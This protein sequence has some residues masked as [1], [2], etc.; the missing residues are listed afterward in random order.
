MFEELPRPTIFAHRG[1]SAHAPE[2][3]LAAFELA[4]RQ[5]ADAI[6][7]D[8]MLCGDDQM[9]VFHDE[10]LE[11]TTDGSGLVRELPL[12]ALKELDAGGFFDARFCGEK[13]PTLEE[14]FET[15]GS[16]LFINI[17]IKNYASPRDDLPD[18]VAELVSKYNLEKRVIVSS[19]NPFA[20]KRFRRLL[21]DIPLGFLTTSGLAGLA[22]RIFFGPWITY[23][24]IHAS[25][26][27]STQKFVKKQQRRGYRVH[28]YTVNNPD[29]ILRMLNWGVDG[30]FTDDPLLARQIIEAGKVS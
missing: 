5:N 10:S 21:P 9:V 8:V 23:Q 15:V 13:I 24:A 26:S 17:E 12:A 20:L 19:F 27:G 1:A 18:K 28:I 4:L 29:D 16:K 6:E 7:L 2:N 25:L 3:T 14:V 30:F 11:R 22:P